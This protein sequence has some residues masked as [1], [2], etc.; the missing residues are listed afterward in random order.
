MSECSFGFHQ[1]EGYRRIKRVGL[2]KDVGFLGYDRPE[3]SGWSGGGETG[4]KTIRETRSMCLDEGRR[5]CGS[6]EERDSGNVTHIKD[7]R[8]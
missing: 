1:R 3:G 8:F 4:V 5:H 7:R 6:V 2:R